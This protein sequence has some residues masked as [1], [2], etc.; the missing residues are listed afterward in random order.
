MAIQNLFH[1]ERFSIPCSKFHSDISFTSFSLIQLIP[2]GIFISY[3]FSS[4]L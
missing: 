3:T 2:F 1:L 4:S